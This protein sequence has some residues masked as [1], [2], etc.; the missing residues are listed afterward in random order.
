MRGAIQLNS[1]ALRQIIAPMP[2]ET[3]PE[4]SH[5]VGHSIPEVAAGLLVGIA[6]AT[7]ARTL[8]LI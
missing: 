3:R 5:N 6:A 4:T 8:N 1:E 7:I 2:E